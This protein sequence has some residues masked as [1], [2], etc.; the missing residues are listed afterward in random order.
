MNGGIVQVF[1]KCPTCGSDG[2]RVRR[3]QEWCL[4]NGY[5]III[6]KLTGTGK[7]KVRDRWKYYLKEKNIREEVGVIV[8]S[9]GIIERLDRWKP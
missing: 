4:R 6:F 3:L 1:A 7:Q 2:V 9:D 8:F 5:D